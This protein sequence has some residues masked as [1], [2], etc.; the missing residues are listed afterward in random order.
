[1]LSLLHNINNPYEDIHLCALLKSP[2]FDI[3]LDELICIRKY[4]PDLPFLTALEQFTKETGFAKGEYFLEK[5][6]QYRARSVSMPA[7]ELIWYLFSDTGFLSIVYA[8]EEFENGLAAK[9]EQMRANL[10][11]FYEYARRF[12][13][14][15]FRG[16]GSFIRYI[17]E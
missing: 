17:A 1:M 10:L 14:N 4:A 5:L 3:S 9:P 16:L 15:S 12:E 11:L 7:D 6:A 13:K 8:R 2:L